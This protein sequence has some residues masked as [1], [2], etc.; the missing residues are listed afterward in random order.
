MPKKSET[1]STENTME[2]NHG[3]IGSLRLGKPCQDHGV[4]DKSSTKLCHLV[5]H[6]RG[7]G[8]SATGTAF[9]SCVAWYCCLEGCLYSSGGKEPEKY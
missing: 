8:D 3:I 1:E 9:I 5:P 4:T 7:D 2:Q 6:L